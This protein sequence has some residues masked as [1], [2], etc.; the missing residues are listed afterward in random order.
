MQNAECKMQNDLS[1]SVFC[2]LRFAF[3]IRVKNG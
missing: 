2:I 1:R 3:C